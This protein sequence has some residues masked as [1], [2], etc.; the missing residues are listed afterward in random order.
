MNR[1][2]NCLSV[3]WFL[4]NVFPYIEDNEIQLIIIGGNPTKE[5]LDMQ[6]ERVVVT[7]YVN[8]VTQYFRNCMCM[9]APLV[10]GAGIKVKVLEAMSAGVP[11]LTNDI[12]IEGINAQNGI[13][14]FQ[15]DTPEDYLQTIKL[16]ADN[17]IN[18]SD[19]S[20]E[21]K[22]LIKKEYNIHAKVNE[23]YDMVLRE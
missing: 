20:R 19:M 22:C 3:K 17:K 10:L 6:N 2:E 7:G 13:H 21:M 18:I 8:D 14:Y 12:G 9:V 1:L 4:D 23:L 11:I 5:I 15:C 16:L